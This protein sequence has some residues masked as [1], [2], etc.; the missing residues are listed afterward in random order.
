MNYQNLQ[1]IEG[2]HFLP[3]GKNKAP[4]EKKWQIADKKHDLSNCYGVGILCGEPSNNLE[5][6][7]V[8]EKYD[9]T[10]KL[11]ERYKNAVHEIN[12]ALLSKLVVEKTPSGGHHLIYRCASIAGNTKLANRHT[13][14][15]EKIETYKLTFE[16]EKKSGKDEVEAKKIAEKSSQNDTS[17]VLLETRG[18]GGQFNCSPTPG[19]EFVYGDLC[20]VSEITPEERD[21]LIGCARQFNEYYEEVAYTKTKIDKGIGTSPFDDYNKNGDIVALLQEHGWKVVKQHGKKT[22][23]LRPGQTTSQ[24]SGNFDHEKNWFSVFTTSSE[25]EPMKAYLPYAVFSILE[26]NKDFSEAARKLYEM[27]YGERKE[28]KEQPSTRAI[29]SRVSSDDNDFSF[30]AKEEDYNTYLD[31]VI[32][33]TVEMGLSTGSPKLDEHFLFKEGNMVS[34][35]GIDNVGKTAWIWWLELIAAMYHGWKGIIFASENTIGGFMRKMIQFYWGK[36]LRGNFA[37]SE[38]EFKIAKEFIEKHFFI[39]K[40]QEELY[41]YKDILNLVKKARQ[42][43]SINYCMID[44]YN[45]LKVDLSGF[46]KLNTHE[47]HYEA[48]SELKSYGQQTKF[49][50]FINHH[51][52]TG[53]A[54]L[55]DGEK[56]YPLAPRKED[57]EHGVKVPNK[58]D[59]FLTVHR[60]TQHPT[61]WT[62]TEVHVRKIKDTETGGR[63][64]SIDNPIKFELYK[65]G[66]AFIEKSELG[67]RGVDP[68]EQWHFKKNGIKQA[69]T[70]MSIAVNNWLP[71]KGDNE[72]EI[73]F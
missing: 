6:I 9:L 20:S 2:F 57:T 5:C 14:E 17:R 27:G 72:T 26:C 46:S 56:K 49:G 7:D 23:F 35:N 68:I 59:D 41:N 61:D 32:S 66:C 12:D 3:I 58:T 37:M 52:Y 40:A 63:P 42:K 67:A 70:Q 50:W 65:W 45:S 43:Y 71:Y 19:Y 60:L 15:E 28:K 25:F 39:I 8:D 44:P 55:K 48:L 33:G 69:N 53:A 24:S 11:F 21:I 4:T 16:K 54:R 22:I 64:T 73:N 36:P 18:S 1:S 10:G 47:Y 13:T 51:A 62:I 30:L 29:P 34:V 38:K 31:Q